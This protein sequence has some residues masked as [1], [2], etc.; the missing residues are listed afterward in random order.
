VQEPA[1]LIAEMRRLFRGHE[2]AVERT[3][4]VVGRCR[5]S[6]DELRYEYPEEPVPAGRTPQAYLEEL[7]WQGAAG[8][9]PDGLAPEIEADLRHELALIGKLGYAAYF[10]TVHDIVGEARRRGILCQGRGSAA[11]SAVCYCLGITGVNPAEIDLLFERF[12]S[13]GAVNL[14]ISTSI[15]STSGARR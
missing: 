3:L 6:L 4:A 7:T 15:S 9:W 2:D 5:F 10:L 8:R 11:N 1:H 14:P 12:V 13:E